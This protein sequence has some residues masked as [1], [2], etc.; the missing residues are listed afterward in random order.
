MSEVDQ[1]KD[2]VSITDVVG[3]YVELKKAGINYTGLCPFHH[4]K[5]PSFFVSPDRGTFKCFGCG[6]GGDI[7]TF[8]EKIEGQSFREVLEKFATETGIQLSNNPQSGTR[9][10]SSKKKEY[11]RIMDLAR[12]FWQRQL[13]EHPQA[14][15]YLKRRGFSKDQVVNYAIGYAPAQWDSLKKYLTEKGV[16]EE[17]MITVGLVKQGDKGGVYDR[18]RDRIVFPL[19]NIAGQTIAV[20]GRYIGSDD[21]SAKYLNSP[22]TPI[23]HKSKEL[24]GFDTAKHA[25][26]KNNFAIVVEGQVDLVMGQSVYPNTVATSGTALTREHLDAIRRFADRIVLVFD[27]DKAGV[28]AA[29][30]AS[31][32]CLDLDF[33]VRIARLPKDKDP[34]DIIAESRETYTQVIKDAKD[35]FGYWTYYINHA[36]LDPRSRSKMIS[37]R[38]LP[39]LQSQTNALEQERYIAQVAHALDTT[40]DAIRIEL[41]KL[42]NSAQAVPQV[43][44]P[45]VDQEA[46]KH[47]P[48]AR[49]AQISA[50]HDSLSSEHALVDIEQC[51]WSKLD[52][53]SATMLRAEIETIDQTEQELL[54]FEFEKMYQSSIILQNDIQ[55]LIE[56][57]STYRFT[58]QQNNLLQQHKQALQQGD[59]ERAHSILQEL[60]QLLSRHG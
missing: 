2:A 33:E 4:E 29:F 12:V 51:L 44:Q 59:S 10:G 48:L 19:R 13:V 49:L 60:Q 28:N 18:F 47:N 25:M 22:E 32:I 42:E 27:S 8:V 11:Y 56:R 57:L 26:R 40:A 31:L 52:E 23:F 34:A 43:K 54:Y 1:I 9:E 50:W 21:V 14:I 36:E 46:P 39:L 20:S 55:E 24:Y 5:T 30:K 17:D 38:L 35:V 7:F 37:E 58:T 53:E 45:V 16:S 15:D 3:R 6:E 41:A